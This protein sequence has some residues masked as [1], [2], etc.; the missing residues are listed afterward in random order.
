MISPIS[1]GSKIVD[2]E[3]S[4]SDKGHVEVLVECVSPP[5]LYLGPPIHVKSPRTMLPLQTP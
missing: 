5:T 4:V 2:V 3:R 1:D